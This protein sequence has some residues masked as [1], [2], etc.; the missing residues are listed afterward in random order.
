MAAL[1][2][3]V[4]DA[5]RRA[6]HDGE[7]GVLALVLETEGSTYVPAGAAA[8]FGAHA[9][10]GWLSGGCLETEIAQ[11]AAL[12]CERSELGWLELDTRADDLGQKVILAAARAS[13][14]VGERQ[15]RRLGSHPSWADGIDADAFRAKLMRHDA[16]KA[17][18]GVF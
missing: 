16:G 8:W 18:I 4:L 15:H 12:A 5:V 17:Q 2:R 13:R 11:H 10:A 6:L 7:P 9:H 1:H 3:S 14:H